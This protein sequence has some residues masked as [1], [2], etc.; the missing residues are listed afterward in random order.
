M[1]YSRKHITCIFGI[2]KKSFLFLKY[3]IRLYDL[4]VIK[5][6]FVTCCVLHNLLLEYDGMDNWEYQLHNNE[7]DANVAYG[8]LETLSLRYIK[9]YQ[10]NKPS[11]ESGISRSNYNGNGPGDGIA[12]DTPYHEPDKYVELANVKYFFRKQRKII[13]E[14]FG[15]LKK[16]RVLHSNLR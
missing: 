16:R 12:I 11:I 4:D 7:D 2:L 14:H 8:T 3:P 5:N 13:V 10:K 15:I 1:E 9:H 6:T